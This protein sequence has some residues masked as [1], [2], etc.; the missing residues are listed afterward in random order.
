MG[1]GAR[2]VTVSD[3]PA[4]RSTVWLPIFTLPWTSTIRCAPGAIT[5][6]TGT[7][8]KGLPSMTTR[9]PLGPLTTRIETRCL[10]VFRRPRAWAMIAGLPPWVDATRR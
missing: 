9:E 10:S 6:S 3:C 4:F 5:T 2:T 1:I 7:T 8:P